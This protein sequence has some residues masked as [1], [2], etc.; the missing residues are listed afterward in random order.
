MFGGK[1]TGGSL[2]ILLFLLLFILLLKFFYITTYNSKLVE[3]VIFLYLRKQI[4]QETNKDDVELKIDEGQT[5]A[6]ES[7]G[8]RKNKNHKKLENEQL[9]M[10]QDRKVKECMVLQKF[11]YFCK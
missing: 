10:K 9:S 11:N 6:P 1:R 2:K 7:K 8:R 4:S 5:E 3:Y